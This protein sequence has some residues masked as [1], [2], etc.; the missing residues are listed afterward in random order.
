RLRSKET[1]RMR[2]FYNPEQ[3]LHDPLQFMRYGKLIAPKD[4]PERT[5]RLLGALER[6]GMAPER[7]AA[8][9]KAPALAV[10]TQGY[11]DFLESVWGRWEML[12]DHGPEVWPNTFPYWSGR[13]EE[14]ARRP[15]PCEGIVGQVGWYLGDLSVP[16]GPNTWLSTL[17]SSETAASAADA[18]IA[19]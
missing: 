5:A 3:A 1:D 13:P 15:C 16:M 7:P 8:H 10:H 19:G 18:L 11:V 12:P 14:E 9:G 2:A 17:R 6:H 4:V